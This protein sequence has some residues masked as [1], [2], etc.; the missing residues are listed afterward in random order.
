MHERLVYGRLHIPCC[1]G[2][3]FCCVLSKFFLH[4]I[5]QLALSRGVEGRPGQV[6]VW[7]PSLRSAPPPSVL[8]L[9]NL[10]ELVLSPATMCGPGHVGEKQPS[11]VVLP[12][13]QH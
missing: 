11:N 13:S 6:C 12:G 4:G 2:S 7:V 3:D 10:D 9:S 5:L 1:V 8:R